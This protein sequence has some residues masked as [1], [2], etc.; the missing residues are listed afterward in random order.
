[1]WE[2]DLSGVISVR[3]IFQRV[4]TELT[5]IDVHATLRWWLFHSSWGP[6]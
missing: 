2:T 6:C 5:Y 3:S 4:L 1:M